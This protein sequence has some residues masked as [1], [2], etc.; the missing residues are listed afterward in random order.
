MPGFSPVKPPITRQCTSVKRGFTRVRMSG[1]VFR[2]LE[3]D[4][5]TRSPAAFESISE[6]IAAGE[7]F[8]GG[9]KIVRHGIG[10]VPRS[11]ACPS[12]DAECEEEAPA[13]RLRLLV[14]HGV[15]D[16]RPHRL[17]VRIFHRPDGAKLNPSTRVSRRHKRG[18]LT[19]ALGVRHHHSV[20]LR[21]ILILAPLSLVGFLAPL[22]H[23]SLAEDKKALDL[24]GADHPRPPGTE[25]SS[26]DVDAFSRSSGGHLHR[27]RASGTSSV[28]SD[29][30]DSCASLARCRNRI[31][32]MY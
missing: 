8:Y 9:G 1:L 3:V 29:R 5:L 13:R 7:V 27:S 12:G 16:G 14:A 30:P 6:P 28:R 11:T 19:R 21:L 17:H 2:P 32:D 23:G 22:S 31:S 4:R 26:A 25:A 10:R 24:R 15:T 18:R 20:G